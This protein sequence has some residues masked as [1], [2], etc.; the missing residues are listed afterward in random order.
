[1]TLTFG[2]PKKQNLE[3]DFTDILNYI[4]KSPV[5]AKLNLGDS[6]IR[7]ASISRAEAAL[8]VYEFLKLK[9]SNFKLPYNI[10]LYSNPFADLDKNTNYYDA[11]IT[12]VNYKGDDT[13]TV[14][15]KKF[16]VF[17]PLDYVT[18]FQFVKMI[19]EGLN[20]PKIYDFSYIQNYYDYS[21]LGDDAKIYFATAVKNGIIKGDN[22]KLLPYQDLTI[23][24]ALTILDRVKNYNFNVN[25]NQFD[26]PDFED[27]GG[28]TLGIIPD[29]QVYNPEVQPIKINGIKYVKDGNCTKLTVDASLDTNVTGYYVWSANFGYFKK[30]DENNK[31]VIFC[32]ATKKPD[33]DYQIK[34]LGNDGY[35]NFDEY[36]ITLNRN[37]YVY[38]QNIADKNV[39]VVKFNLSLSLPNKKMKENGLFV[40]D[41]TGSVYKNNLNIGLEKVSVVLSD[42]NANY[43]IDNVKWND[44]SIYFIVPTIKEFYGKDLNIKV[45]VGSNDKFKSFGFTN[46]VYHP[47]YTINGYVAADENGTF[48]QYVNIN[49]SKIEVNNGNFVYFPKN[50]GSFTVSVNEPNYDS[51]TVTLTDENPTAN[52]YIS[53]NLPMPPDINVTYPVEDIN[54]TNEQNQTGDTNQTLPGENQNSSDNNQTIPI[55]NNTTQIITAFDPVTGE[56]KEFNSTDE[57][58]SNWMQGVPIFVNVDKGI[59]LVSR[60]IDFKYL[61]KDVLIVWSLNPQTKEWEAYSPDEKIREMI[62]MN[63]FKFIDKIDATRGFFVVADKP[64]RLVTYE[65]IETNNSIDLFNLPKGYTF[66]G[67]NNSEISVYDIKCQDGYKVGGVFK[68]KNGHWIHYIPSLNKK[69]FEY[70]EQNEG[71]LVQ[72]IPQGGEK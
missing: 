67:S 19:I 22:N 30:V 39:S 18:R 65:N 42:G 70:I 41:K 71:A 32:P 49:S 31:E 72:C 1:Q 37:D 47:V 66:I 24:Q 51:Q 13:I 21:V 57:I 60:N 48:P 56:T 59:S 3:E 33:V 26:L 16:G 58:P 62:K 35:F 61:P 53:Y 50:T 38:P 52:V 20:I 46:I 44:N 17:N 25:T 7:Y 43:V 29:Y 34:V 2:I 12:L 54:Q 10:E 64:V 6:K 14:L 69:E 4:N 45:I 8:I 23:F 36:T 9:N 63:G 27:K 11:V 40:I 55:E 15:T 5:I 68:Y 28:T